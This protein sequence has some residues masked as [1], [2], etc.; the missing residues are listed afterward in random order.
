MSW[1]ILCVEESQ[2]LNY[3]LNHIGVCTN[4][5]I[6][7]INLDEIDTIIIT[8]LK[9]NITMRLI[10]ELMEKGINLIVCDTNHQPVGSIITL[11]NNSRM[12]KNT[13]NQ[14]EWKNEVKSKIWKLI[15]QY[16]I[17][18]Q[19]EVLL[20]LNK[21]NKISYLDKY[22]SEVIDGDLTN[23]EGLAAKVYFRELFGSD[24]NRNNDDI[25]NSSLNYIYQIIRS[26]IGQE[27]VGRGYIPSFGIFH[28]NEY[29]DFNFADDIIEV[30]RPICDYYV[31]NLLK[32]NNPKFLN[33]KYKSELASILIY[34]IKIK[35]QHQKISIAITIFIDSIINYLNEKSNDIYFPTI[36]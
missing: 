30:F 19:K 16:K 33:P 24:F 26:K 9:C 18:L 21:L 15:V 25:I 6:L 28:C 12:S 2:K 11:S 5:D 23:R 36:I 10:K 32:K 13:L 8:D 27:I 35:G 29:N 20:I 34:K 7:W 1:R 4:E 17:L 22:V 14:L 31:F 3:R